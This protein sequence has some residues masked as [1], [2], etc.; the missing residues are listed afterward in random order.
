MEKRSFGVI[1]SGIMAINIGLVILFHAGMFIK[2]L[3]GG[4]FGL[5][6]LFLIV[7]LVLGVSFIASGIAIFKLSNWG[8]VLFL[9][10]MAAYLLIGLLV[11]YIL[12]MVS[13]PTNPAIVRYII[14]VGI[15]LVFF[16]FPSISVFY[17][18]TRAKVKEMFK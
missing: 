12:A 9:W 13:Y 18:F 5:Q 16:I 4:L 11:S 6:F 1:A 7:E 8:R 3:G 15:Y 10:L 14:P 17:F 2:A